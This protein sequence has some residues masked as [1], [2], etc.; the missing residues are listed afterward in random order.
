MRD[1]FDCEIGYSDHSTG[2]CVSIAA[3]ALGATIIEKHFTLDR[4]FAGPDHQA[5]IEPD[6]LVSL[7]RSIR[8][9]EVALG[10]GI[11]NPSVS[12]LKNIASVR[13]SIVAITDIKIGEKFSTDNL[14]IKRPGGGMDPFDYWGM[15]GKPSSKN[16][17]FDDLIDE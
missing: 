16:Y 17:N 7:V 4:C 2:I 1:Y 11:K 10:S 13:K 15:M 5:S 3:A 6:E 8:E 12:E 9:V 14:D